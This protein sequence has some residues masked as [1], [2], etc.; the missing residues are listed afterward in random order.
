MKHKVCSLE[1]LLGV[2]GKKIASPFFDT[3]ILNRFGI[4]TQSLL[5]P[6]RERALRFLNGAAGSPGP[7][8]VPFR[9]YALLLLSALASLVAIVVGWFR[10]SVAASMPPLYLF[11][12][13]IA[14]LL[15]MFFIVPAGD[16]RYLMPAAACCAISPRPAA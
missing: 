8:Q 3:V 9:H 14:V 5:P 10:G 6:V 12:G 2:T 11:L 1:S 4:H 7:L 15:P 16:W 13:G